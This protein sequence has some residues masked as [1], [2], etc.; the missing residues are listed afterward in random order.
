VTAVELN[1]SEKAAWS[2]A[3]KQ[4]LNL[5][6]APAFAVEPDIIGGA[7]LRLPHAAIRFTWAD[8]VQKAAE[9]LKRDQDGQAPT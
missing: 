9:L 7:E 5:P 1:E 3:L 4:K 8:Q 6:D 2:E